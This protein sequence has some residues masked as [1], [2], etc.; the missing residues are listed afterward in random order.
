M[1]DYKDEIVVCSRCGKEFVK[2]MLYF[3]CNTESAHDSFYCCPYCNQTYSIR[4]SPREDV[5]TFKVEN[6]HKK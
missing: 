5:L 1:R 6:F 2:R 3:P 4:L